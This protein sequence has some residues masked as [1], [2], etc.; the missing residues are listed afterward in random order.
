MTTLYIDMDGVVADFDRYAQETLGLPPS[1]GMY[2]PEEWQRIAEN[3][4]IYRDLEKTPYADKL[5]FRSEEH[6]S[7]LQ[8]H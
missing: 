2:P 3:D 6:T 5:V 4:R 1:G 8:S 7:E